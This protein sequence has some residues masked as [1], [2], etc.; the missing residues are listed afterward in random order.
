MGLI[1]LLVAA[2]VLYGLAYLIFP[3]RMVSRTTAPRSEHRWARTLLIFA[4]A[5]TLVLSLVLLGIYDGL[6]FIAGLLLITIVSLWWRYQQEVGAQLY[7]RI[8]K[9][10][11][12]PPSRPSLW[13]NL[14]DRLASRSVLSGLLLLGVVLGSVVLRLVPLLQSPAPFSVT[15]YRLLEIAK[16]L[17]ANQLFPGQLLEARGAQG[18]SVALHALSGVDL[19]I[20]VR[21]LGVAAVIG[22]LLGIYAAIQGYTGSPMAALGGTA[23]FGLGLPV[24]PL[25]LENQVEATPTLLAAAWA[26]P[27]WYV[28]LRYQVDGLRSRLWVGVMGLGLLLLTE[29]TVAALIITLLFALSLLQSMWAQ[30][31]LRARR[32]LHVVGLSLGSGGL[33]GGLVVL[34]RFLLVP[35]PYAVPVFSVSGAG[36][37][38]S[39][40]DLSFLTYGIFVGATVLALLAGAVVDPQPFRRFV[41]WALALT[42]MGV[43]AAWLG[44]RTLPDL[45]LS[46]L[47]PI[48]LL[49][50][51]LCVAFGGLL[52]HV[53]APLR[54]RL[55]DLH[56]T[57]VVRL[58]YYG[59]VPGLLL[60]SLF[61]FSP[62]VLP[63]FEREIEP[64]GYV[65]A[66]QKIQEAGIPY[67]WT[68]VSHHGTAVH[69]MNR[70][71]FLTH[72][73][74]LQHYDAQT[75]DP[76]GPNAIPTNDLFLFVP[77]ESTIAAVR[78]ELLISGSDIAQSMQRWCELYQQRGSLSVFF[79]DDGLT[80]YRLTRPSPATEREP[81]VP[82]A[83]VRYPPA[84]PT[85]SHGQNAPTLP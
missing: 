85:Q 40:P 60:V 29:G 82:R 32:A 45:D 12:H 59:S 22:L 77:T 23:L 36:A 21:L 30:T 10:A 28:L 57:P 43:F 18:L 74:F 26:L 55:R 78:E 68:V 63:T 79:E 2:G 4:L 27:T 83:P 75:Y 13:P 3:L 44:I 9:L 34:R 73:Y 16:H 17:Q 46:P 76:A 51:F 41:S 11:D 49:S 35:D 8:L 25:A 66:I 48:T 14:T 69:A 64:P 71:R 70:G 47:A 65:R 15:H 53:A 1:R 19:W 31:P 54:S 61:L 42:C 7:V 56:Q 5:T 80:V 67:Q 81:L 33:L 52:G 72:D 38:F 58:A 20:V 62:P 24:V 6:T 50:I 39:P 37:A 84:A